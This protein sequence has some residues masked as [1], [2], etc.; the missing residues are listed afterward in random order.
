MYFRSIGQMLT[1]NVVVLIPATSECQV[2]NV[3]QCH[4]NFNGL[5]LG[6]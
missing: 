6:L 4:C 2:S 1:L 5:W 3:S